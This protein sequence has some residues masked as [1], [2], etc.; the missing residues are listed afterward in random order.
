V[1]RELQQQSRPFHPRGRRKTTFWI[2]LID[3]KLTQSAVSPEAKLH[4]SVLIFKILMLISCVLF[5]LVPQ[6]WMLVV[7]MFFGA[8]STVMYSYLDKNFIMRRMKEFIPD[9][10]MRKLE[11]YQSSNAAK[12][13]KVGKKVFMYA[14][15]YWKKRL[16]I[17][18]SQSMSIDS[19]HDATQED[20]LNQDNEQRIQLN[21]HSETPPTPSNEEHPSLT[22]RETLKK[23]FALVRRKLSNDQPLLG[24]LILST[25]CFI[26]LLLFMSGGGSIV[27]PLIMK[28]FV[29]ERGWLTEQQFVNGHTL[30]TSMP[31]PL[32]NF[33]AYVGAVMGGWQ[34]AILCWFA[35]FLPGFLFI[36][37][38]LPIW[39]KYRENEMVQKVL[40]GI[41][42]VAIGFVYAAIFLLWKSAVGTNYYA[43]CSVLLSFCINSV[44][45]MPAPIAVVSGGLFRFLLYLIFK[46]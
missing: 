20:D 16:E 18:I 25:F 42:A 45:G 37:G 17:T 27:V 30:V 33:S 22:F 15:T 9:E 29:V 13:K 19:I 46:N 2:Q 26:Y 34:G 8:A 7:L 11:E 3:K 12:W 32:F 38:V 5:M 28:E 21:P 6:S 35:L 39:R 10:E 44:Y 24:I 36:W 43:M 40:C 41:N 1:T 31:G 14:S 4:V 23:R